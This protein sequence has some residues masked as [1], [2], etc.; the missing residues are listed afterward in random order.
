MSMRRLGAAGVA[1]SLLWMF[2]TRPSPT[3]VAAT[4]TVEQRR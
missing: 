3:V 1:W 2:T 4:A